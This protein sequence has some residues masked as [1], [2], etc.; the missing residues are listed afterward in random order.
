MADENTGGHKDPTDKSSENNLSLAENGAGSIET[1]EE[2]GK[3]AKITQTDRLN[4]RLLS[5]FLDRLNQLDA[6][7][8]LPAVERIDT[9]DPEADLDFEYAITAKGDSGDSGGTMCPEK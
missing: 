9:S 4:K 8:G 1:E 2:Q 3:T 5:S 6:S 7:G